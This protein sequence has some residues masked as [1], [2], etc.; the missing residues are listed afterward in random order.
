MDCD[1]QGSLRVTKR[2]RLFSP[3]ISEKDSTDGAKASSI[4]PPGR[5]VGAILSHDWGGK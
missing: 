5:G 3:G 4:S 2:V 1:T